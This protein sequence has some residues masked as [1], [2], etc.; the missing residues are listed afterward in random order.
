MSAE[1]VLDGLRL[2]GVRVEAVGDRLRLDAPPGAIPPAELALLA[3]R[4]SEL[5]AALGGSAV[6][7]APEP[8]PGHEAGVWW[9]D[10]T[11]TPRSADADG[12]DR[13]TRAAYAP[14]LLLPPRGCLGPIVCARLGRCERAD[15]GRPCRVDGEGA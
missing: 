9:P 8:T 4:K 14:I 6:V 5:L 13:G 11:T 3:A 12:W 1:A 10:P 2:R 15:A 7:P